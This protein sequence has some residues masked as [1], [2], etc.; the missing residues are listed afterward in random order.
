MCVTLS[1][2]VDRG[3]AAECTPRGQQAVPGEEDDAGP[4]RG[5]EEPR[6]LLDDDAEASDARGDE[7]D[8]AREADERERDR[9]SPAAVGMTDPL[10]QE[11]HVLRAG[12]GDD[13]QA[14][15]EASQESGEHASII[16]RSVRQSKADTDIRRMVKQR[17]C[18]SHRSSPKPWR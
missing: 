4:A 1:P 12:R 15:A 3:S 5:V 16:C 17:S 8:V 13:R 6:H 9:V 11:E 7:D 14:Q 18:G 2:D 10:T